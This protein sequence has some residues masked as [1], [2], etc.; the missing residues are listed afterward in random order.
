VTF[1]ATNGGSITSFPSLAIV[2][3][4]FG[5]NVLGDGLRAVWDPRVSRYDTRETTIVVFAQASIKE[6]RTSWQNH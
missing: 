5:F 4:V 3:T 1:C 2:I 6:Q